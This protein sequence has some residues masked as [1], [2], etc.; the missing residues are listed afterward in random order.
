MGN[1]IA[2][3]DNSVHADLVCE[4]GAWAATRLDSPLALLHVVAA[5]GERA[6]RADLSGAIGI[7]ENTHLLERLAELD[8]ARGKLEQQRGKLILEHAAAQLR[9]WGIAPAEALHRRGSLAE[10][11]AELS[12]QAA[13][14]VMGK[15]G[16]HA[17]TARGHLGANL[18]RVA[19]A[20]HTPLLVA[21]RDALPI[22]RVLIAYDGSPS[23]A[24]AIA[25]AASSSLLRGLECDLLQV[26]ERHGDGPTLQQ[27]AETLTQAGLAVR[28][29]LERK[30]SVESAVAAHIAAHQINLLAI[31][32]YGHGTIRS[33]LL[34]STTTA[35]IRATAIPLLLFR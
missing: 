29:T 4:L 16:E 6:A 21:S 13:L 12:G 31:G 8:E 7:D 10:T 9:H 17:G 33:R 20:I 23:A 32:A 3:V 35:L 27:A 30:K 34:G 25:Y 24:K 15:H 5:Q 28:A 2:C 18:E 19:R 14:I 22:R 11:I 1:V 26:G